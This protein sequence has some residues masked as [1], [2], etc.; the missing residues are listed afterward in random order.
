MEH[1]ST[2]HTVASQAIDITALV[3]SIL[4]EHCPT[5]SRLHLGIRIASHRIHPRVDGIEGIGRRPH[6]LFQVQHFVELSEFVSVQLSFTASKPHRSLLRRD[7][8]LG[9]GH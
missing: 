7:I 4:H 3:H 5:R 8:S 2:F 9:L 1:A 6:L